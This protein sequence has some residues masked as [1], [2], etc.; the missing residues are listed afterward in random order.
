MVGTKVFSPWT[1]TLSVGGRQYSSEASMQPPLL[2]ADVKEGRNENDRAQNRLASDGPSDLLLVSGLG[3]GHL[4]GRHPR[5]SHLALLGSEHASPGNVIRVNED[6]DDAEDNR[7]DSLP[8]ED[9]ACFALRV[10]DRGDL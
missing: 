6:H 1:V 10:S 3:L 5:H 8:G 4:T 7:D 9:V 2:T